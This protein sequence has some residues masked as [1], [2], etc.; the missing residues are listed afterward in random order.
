MLENIAHG[1][2]NGDIIA[3]L[4]L[5]VHSIQF[6]QQYVSIHQEGGKD[7][8]MRL[9]FNLLNSPKK[10][11]PAFK[12]LFSGA[13]VMHNRLLEVYHTVSALTWTALSSP[14]EYLLY[15]WDHWC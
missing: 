9:I 15:S 3:L 14:I 10:D 1:T 12:K 4:L 5:Q 6:A 11:Y 13:T 2:A 7:S 8:M